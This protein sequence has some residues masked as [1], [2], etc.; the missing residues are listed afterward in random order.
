MTQ[1]DI[2]ASFDM[3]DEMFSNMCKSS[4]LSDDQGVYVLKEVSLILGVS[5]ST[6]RRW[7]DSG[8]LRS[9][10]LGPRKRVVAIQEIKRYLKEQTANV[11]N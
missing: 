8:T 9:W 5:L 4:G 7:S 1:N 3:V 10:L 6:V 11:A 2:E